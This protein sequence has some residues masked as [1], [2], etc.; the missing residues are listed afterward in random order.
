MTL[1]TNP[2]IELPL[3]KLTAKQKWQV[4]EF[5]CED[6]SSNHA[7]QIEPPT[8]HADVLREREERE[9]R[10]E[11]VWHDVDEAFAEIRRRVS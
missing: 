11:A 2:P 6:L 9:A 8:W 7:G 1:A 10:G 5:L 3:E 4:V